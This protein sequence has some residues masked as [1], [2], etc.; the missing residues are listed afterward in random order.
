VQT[1]VDTLRRSI[2]RVEKLPRT[3][4]ALPIVLAGGTVKPKGFR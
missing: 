4:R 2:A 3:E 1:L